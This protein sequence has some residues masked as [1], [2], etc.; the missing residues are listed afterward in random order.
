MLP[1]YSLIKLRKNAYLPTHLRDEGPTPRVLIIKVK[2]I[3]NCYLVRY[4]DGYIAKVMPDD[5]NQRSIMTPEH[6]KYADT[7]SQCRACH[8]QFRTTED[9]EDFIYYNHYSAYSVMNAVRNDYVGYLKK[10]HGTTF[11]PELSKTTQRLETAPTPS[12]PTV[13]DRTEREVLIS[14]DTQLK[15]LIELVGGKHQ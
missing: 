10:K 8:V 1:N 3:T 2:D 11:E 6:V 13:D 5:I 15:T 12:L 7:I 14:I 4:P 9:Y